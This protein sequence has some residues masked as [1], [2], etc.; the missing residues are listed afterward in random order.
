MQSLTVPPGLVGSGVADAGVDVSVV[1]RAGD[2]DASS[3]TNMG[4]AGPESVELFSNG[5]FGGERR[6]WEARWAR[7]KG[8][9][10]IKGSVDATSQVRQVIKIF[11]GGIS[12]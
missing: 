10:D 1:S 12:W 7:V 4:E 8:F 5:D 2:A 11:M 9:C 3:S 6:L